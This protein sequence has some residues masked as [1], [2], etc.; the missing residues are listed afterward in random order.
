[1]EMV[2]ELSITTPESPEMFVPLNVKVA[3]AIETPTVSEIT[4][5]EKTKVKTFLL[6]A[7]FIVVFSEKRLSRLLL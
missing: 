1:M 6:E 2:L 7:S 4:T 5:T 3:S